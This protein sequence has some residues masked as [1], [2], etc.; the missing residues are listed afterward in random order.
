[1]R[2][3]IALYLVIFSTTNVAKSTITRQIPTDWSKTFH[4]VVQT[5]HTESYYQTDISSVMEK[6]L[7][8]FVQEIDEHARFLGPDSYKEL[9]SATSGTF[10][11]I[12]VDLSPHKNGDGS[13]TIVNIVPGSPADRGGLKK[14]DKIITIDHSPT[15]TLSIDDIL[16]KIRGTQQF[17]PINI[18]CMREKELHHSMLLR[19]HIPEESC[20]H[21]L[22]DAN[23]ILYCALVSFT[24]Q[25]AAQ[26]RRL[27][28][29][30][31]TKHPRGIILDLRDN[32]GGL[33]QAAVDCASVF[34]PKQSLIVSTKNR[35]GI[36]LDEYRTEQAP[37]IIN[38]PIIILVNES[39]ASSAEI[40]AQALTIHA[41]R[42]S[43]R[44]RSRNKQRIPSPYIFTL[45]TKTFGK[46]SIQEIRPM[47]RNCALQ[48]TTAFYY[49]PDNSSLQSTGIMPDF[50]IKQKPLT[51]DTSSPP[52]P[53]R[54]QLN[55]DNQIAYACSLITE[56]DKART[57]DPQKVRS[58]KS[59]LAWL[60]QAPF[61]LT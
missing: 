48:L 22:I 53:S 50:I 8:A 46:G 4:D 40:F 42:I 24:K 2:L 37:L 39:T 33:L 25:S 38:T 52:V 23:N 19:D 17:S 9:L 27:L 3:K 21:V 55:S 30:S 58:R 6:A 16:Q 28:E 59:A 20:G 11:G 56:L 7:D 43:S 60:K 34:L 18:T 10:F 35:S 29:Q 41:D 47:G 13:L 51:A 26:L 45:G 54:W 14:G 61:A 36:V 31:L 32:S 49:L 1:M 12:G 5:V 44:M 15:K 57:A